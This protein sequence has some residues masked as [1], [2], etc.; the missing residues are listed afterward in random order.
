MAPACCYSAIA[1][2]F[3]QRR[4]QPSTSNIITDSQHVALYPEFA[5]MAAEEKKC[6]QPR[7]VCCNR[8]ACTSTHCDSRVVARRRFAHHP[9]EYSLRGAPSPDNP[10]CRVAA[11]RY[12]AARPGTASAATQGQRAVCAAGSRSPESWMPRLR[13]A[14]SVSGV[15]RVLL[16]VRALPH[17][18]IPLRNSSMFCA[19]ACITRST[20]RSAGSASPR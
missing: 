6:Q 10:R 1:F 20:C 11:A 17:E 8:A 16:S 5:Q 14:A 18:F 12:R 13:G 7:G 19:T 2:V 15:R 9:Q 4:N 3:G